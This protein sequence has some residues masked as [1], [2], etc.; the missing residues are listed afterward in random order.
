MQDLL[1]RMR[2]APHPDRASRLRLVFGIISF[3]GMA[4]IFVDGPPNSARFAVPAMGIAVSQVLSGIAEHVSP[5]P[6]SLAPHLRI[7]AVSVG[8]WCSMWLVWLLVS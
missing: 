1:T 8:V 5:S 3:L 2:D 4:V 7:A 6:P